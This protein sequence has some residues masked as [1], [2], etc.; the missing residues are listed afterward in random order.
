[1]TPSDDL[2]IHGASGLFS[3]SVGFKNFNDNK[4]IKKNTFIPS[5]NF[6]SN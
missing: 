1:M 4:I 2:L 3:T 6:S 5:S